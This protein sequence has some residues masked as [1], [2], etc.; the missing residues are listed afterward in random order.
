M[1]LNYNEILKKGLILNQKKTT[2]N[3]AVGFASTAHQLLDLHFALSSM[4]TDAIRE[5]YI[6]E[7]VPLAFEE[8]PADFMA[9]LFYI[10][11]IHYGLG[12]RATFREILNWVTSEENIK[13]TK[14]EEFISEIPD[15]GRW[16]DLFYIKNNKELYVSIMTSLYEILKSERDALVT[17]KNDVKISLLS[18]WMPSINTSSKEARKLAKDFCKI[19]H[20]KYKDYRKLLSFL[21]GKLD[22]VEKKMCKNNFSGID[23]EKVPSKASL[24]YSDAFSRHDKERYKQYIS[25]VKNGKAKINAKTLFPYEIVKNYFKCDKVNDVYEELWKSLPKLNQTAGYIP[26]CDISGSMYSQIGS[27]C[28]AIEASVALSIYLAENNPSKEFRNTII[29]FARRPSYILLNDSMSL[30]DKIRAIMDSHV[31]YNTMVDRVFEMILDSAIH[32]NLPKD[33]KFPTLLFLTDME[34][35]DNSYQLGPSGIVEDVLM[36]KIEL[37][38]TLA[39]YTAPKCVWWNLNSRTLAIPQVKSNSGVVLMSGFSQ[40]AINMIESE[41]FD[42]YQVLLDTIRVPRYKFIYD[43]FNNK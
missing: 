4:R 18:K 11:D 7:K 33:Y 41:S 31:G 20:I 34:F 25:D 16:D 29:T 23:Y 9:W 10:R 19:N 26:V 43:A 38:Y 5:K 3:G 14:I 8:S 36:K 39:G 30:Y 13:R 17:F 32:N 37:S 6:K 1:S 27:S 35:N 24:I 12:E 40:N 15:Y 21:R 28:M 2:E 42:P 22:V